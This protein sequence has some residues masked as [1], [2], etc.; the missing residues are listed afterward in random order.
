MVEP[1]EQID[2][3]IRKKRTYPTT[4]IKPVIKEGKEVINENKTQQHLHIVS[5]ENS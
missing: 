5:L 3:I 2:H 1:P 4:N